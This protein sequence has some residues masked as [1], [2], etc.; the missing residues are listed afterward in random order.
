MA[1]PFSTLKN[2]YANCLSHMQVTRALAVD[3]A[4]KKVLRPENLDRYMS[5]VA[6]TGV[7]AIFIGVLD[8]RESDCNPYLALG[9]G[10]SWS[11]PSVHEP[12]GFGPFSSW[13]SA[14]KF[15]I[16]YDRLDD[17][18]QP[19]T[20]EYVC[21]KGEMWNGFGPRANGRRT[22]YLWA[23]TNL[24]DPPT[25]LGGKYVADG[26]WSPDTVDAQLGIIPVLYRIGQLRPDLA[27]GHAL[28]EH[29]ATERPPIDNVPAIE[30]IAT[31]ELSVRDVQ[32]MLG[33]VLKLDLA[34]D[35]SY[36][37]QTRV[38]VRLF[39]TKF[40]LPPNGICDPETKSK[41][42]T[43]YRRLRS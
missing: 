38:A 6:G 7:P 15:Y 11:R 23:A 12:K 17:A 39:Q 3:R 28:P 13:V 25:G 1:H 36:G 18:T 4:A 30:H 21:W 22:G 8:L 33:F 40:G 27:I 24:Y 26:R 10:D 34:E 14:A 29:I 35:G 42:E 19:W 37:R 20:M 2:D 31:S 41:L 43:E 9:Q 5:A 16:N 32:H